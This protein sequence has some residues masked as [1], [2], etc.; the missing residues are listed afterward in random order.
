[1]RPEMDYASREEF[2]SKQ[3]TAARVGLR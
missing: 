1:M 3:E 2:P